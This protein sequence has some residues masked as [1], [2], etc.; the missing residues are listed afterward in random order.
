MTSSADSR[1]GRDPAAL[2]ATILEEEARRQEEQQRR[3][4]VTVLPDDRLP[5]VGGEAMPLRDALRT[6]GASMLTVLFLI[7]V[8]DEFDRA[9]FSVLAP[10]IQETFAVSDTVIAAIGGASGA[11]FVLG[12]VPIG[13]L[14]DRVSRTKLAGVATALWGGFVFL[15]GFVRSAF[16]LFVTRALTGIGQ[17]NVLPVNNALIADQYPLEAR[18]RLFGLLGAATPLGRFAAPFAVGAIASIAGGSDGWRWAF[19][20]VAIPPAFLAVAVGVQRDPKRGRYEQRLVLGEELDEDA[21]VPRISMGAA[22]QR[23]KKIRT[24]YFI[25]VGVGALGFA[26]FSIPLFL[27]LYLEERFGY[28][29]WGRGV[30]LGLVQVG[31]LLGAPLAGYF[32]DRLFRRSPVQLL[33]L[34]AAMVGSY[35]IFV[36]LGLYF[37]NI[38]LLWLF[39][40]I[41][42]TGAFAGFV[43]LPP[44]TSAIVPY[45]LR[46]Q[47]F[48]MVGVYIF[49]L[50][51]FGG[52]ILTG[53]LSDSF[54]ERTALLTVAPISTVV[55]GSLIAFGARHVRRDISLV[56]EELR[57]EQEEMLRARANPDDVPVLQVRNLDYSYGRVQV[58]FDVSLEVRRGE[59]LA[60]LG[61]NGA[62]KSTV[63][64]AVSGLGIP[65]RGAVRL[66]GRTITY[67]DAEV[68][69]EMGVVQVAG[70]KAT[71]APLTVEENLRVGAFTKRDDVDARMARVF[72]LFPVLAERRDQPAASLSGGQQQMLALGKALM[73]DPEVLLIDELSLGLAPIVVQELMVVVENLRAAGVTMIIVEQSLNI[74]LALADRAVFMEKGQVR[75]TGPTAELAERDDLVRA[76]FLGAEGG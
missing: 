42:F 58:L 54:G 52:A 31:P 9:A 60:L 65:D 25:L 39:V 72:D 76:V 10:R 33:L 1:S 13:A 15:T 45:R 3:D 48:A 73:L 47:G 43:T 41:G 12:A 75:F 16:A 55:G 37:S 7:Q 17:A 61:T 57:E 44:T 63:L 68:R 35:G 36:V 62:G 71:F 69:V 19:W 46:S 49:L 29:E 14:A 27:S 56:V 66:N 51:A 20:L 18:S 32:A 22:F 59:T 28:D 6:G 34:T 26:L 70:G 40:T 8:F 64:R 53:W 21:D 24:F 2:A 11:L 67:T 30:F 4:D 74:A 50:G 23:L 38:V 5:G